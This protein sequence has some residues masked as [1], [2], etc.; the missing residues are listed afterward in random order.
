VPQKP[1][2][3]VSPKPATLY[4]EA[5]VAQLHKSAELL[6]RVYQ[7]D[8]QA[9]QAADDSHIQLRDPAQS[10]NPVPEH[11]PAAQHQVEAPAYGARPSLADTVA[12]LGHDHDL[13]P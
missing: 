11:D 3:I 5:D 2:R 7:A 1:R 9:R 12:V 13:R 4:E 10:H 8:S 6:N